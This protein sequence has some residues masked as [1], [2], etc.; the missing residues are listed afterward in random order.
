V[1]KKIPLLLLFAILPFIFTMFVYVSCTDKY[2]ASQDANKLG[3]KNGCVSCHLNG[4]KLK[5]LATPLPPP[6]GEAGEG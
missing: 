2:P 1:R 3:T 4:E 5:Q 6:E